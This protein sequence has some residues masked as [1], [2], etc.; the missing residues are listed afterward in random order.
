MDYPDFT[1]NSSSLSLAIF[2]GSQTLSKKSNPLFAHLG[3][4]PRPGSQRLCTKFI[5]RFEMDKL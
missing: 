1:L 5:Q 4:K 3:F 2:C